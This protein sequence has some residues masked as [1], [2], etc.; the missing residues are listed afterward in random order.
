MKDASAILLRV[1][2][3]ISENCDDLVTSKSI[4]IQQKSW[5]QMGNAK[6]IQLCMRLKG[7]HT[8]STQHHAEPSA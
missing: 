5:Q 1:A 4:Q 7:H 2:F 6:Y 3:F 8:S